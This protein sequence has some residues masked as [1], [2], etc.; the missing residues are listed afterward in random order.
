MKRILL[1]ETELTRLI[2]RVVNEQVEIPTDLEGNVPPEAYVKEYDTIEEAIVDLLER[3]SNMDKNGIIDELRRI[4]VS[5]SDNKKV[6]F[7]VS[8]FLKSQRKQW[9][10][11]WSNL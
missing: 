1:S 11:K 7:S 4:L 6:P 2:Q 9:S 10:N 5:T 8:E 3:A